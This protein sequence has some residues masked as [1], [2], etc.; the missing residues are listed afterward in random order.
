MVYAYYV[1]MGGFVAD[2]DHLHNSLKRVTITPTGVVFMT[3]QGQCPRIKRSDIQDKSKADILAKGLVCV[4]VVWTVGQVIERKLASYPL[5]M[6]EVHTIVHVVCALLM[7]GL[8]IQKPL[9]VQDPTVIDF[10]EAPELLGLM[11]QLSVEKSRSLTGFVCKSTSDASHYSEPSMTWYKDLSSLDPLH[12][13]LDAME[14]VL[15]PHCLQEIKERP[16][17]CLSVVVEGDSQP[18]PQIS[19]PF[20]LS[21]KDSHGVVHRYPMGSINWQY[22]P[23]PG[24]EAVCTV[25]AG[26]AL[27]SGIGP[28]LPWPAWRSL[29]TPP[30][31]SAFDRPFYLQGQ[32]MTMFEPIS[33]VSLSKKDLQR[34]SLV[35]TWITKVSRKTSQSFGQSS[36]PQAINLDEILR[37]AGCEYNNLKL[38]SGT[39]VSRRAKNVAAEILGIGRESAYL[40]TVLALLPATYGSVHLVALKI[41]FPTAIEKLLWKSSCFILVGAAAT[42]G[43]LGLIVYADQH[44]SKARQA[45]KERKAKSCSPSGVAPSVGYQSGP[46]DILSNA[47]QKIPRPLRKPI[48]PTFLILFAIPYFAARIY[49]VVESFVSLRHVPI[50]VYQ[51]PSGNFISYIP[52]L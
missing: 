13:D 39:M 1:V 40:A 52:H 34:L 41:I 18:P 11:L 21:S 15:E 3:S 16:E 7:Y 24:A 31:P 38:W 44:I 14:G 43:F 25:V 19:T 17:I 32:Y 2:I 30:P 26:Q 45:Q 9:N 8:W 51:T 23:V 42:Y 27:F 20:C 46:L 47:F 36:F 6:L 4:Q 50:G 22:T 5:T 48:I 37:G 35:N 33:S 29:D 28:K 10:R 12:V 49:L